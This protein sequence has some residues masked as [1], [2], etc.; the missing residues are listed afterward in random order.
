MGDDPVNPRGELVKFVVGC[1]DLEA[2]DVSRLVHI[3]HTRRDV[4]L[5]GAS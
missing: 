3:R 2:E 5:K 4:V 1:G